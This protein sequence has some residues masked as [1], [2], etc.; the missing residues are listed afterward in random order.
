MDGSGVRGQMDG[1][2]GGGGGGGCQTMWFF[3]LSQNC[4]TWVFWEASVSA[5][6]TS[7][8]PPA[9]EPDNDP[10][11]QNPVCVEQ[12]WVSTSGRQQ[13]DNMSEA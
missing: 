11:L 6:D 4:H 10:G 2:G 3:S 7:R 13:C 9:A 1:G 12:G 5:T 8:K